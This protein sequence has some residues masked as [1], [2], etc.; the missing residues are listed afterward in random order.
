[1][2]G[3]KNTIGIVAGS[4][5]ALLLLIQLVPYGHN[6]ANP[7]VTGSPGWDSPETEQLARRACFDCHSNETRWPWYASIAPVS[8][9]VQHH[10][11]EGRSKVNFSEF[12]RPQKEAHES[13]EQVEKGEMPHWDYKIIHPESRLSAGEKRALIA[14]LRATFGERGA[15]NEHDDEDDDD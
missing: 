6:H 15:G 11:E 9:R 8:W 14:G 1:M 13:A 10:V 4:G 7:P 12:N 5:V 3:R 2:T